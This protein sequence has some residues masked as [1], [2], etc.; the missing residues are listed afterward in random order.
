MPMT[1]NQIWLGLFLLVAALA[2]ASDFGAPDLQRDLVARIADGD[3]CSA[4][5]PCVPE[6]AAVR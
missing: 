1:F 4:P 2:A 6:L 3:A 5:A